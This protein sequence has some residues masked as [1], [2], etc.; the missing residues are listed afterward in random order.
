MSGLSILPILTA[1]LVAQPTAPVPQAAQSESLAV[2]AY[3]LEAAVAPSGLCARSKK[4]DPAFCQKLSEQ[5]L[6]KNPFYKGLPRH[7]QDFA[8]QA[9][10]T[11]LLRSFSSQN[12]ESLGDLIGQGD[13][14]LFFPRSWV[15]AS[16]CMSSSR[17]NPSDKY[18]IPL[19]AGSSV[20][21]IL[22][23]AS[24]Y[25]P[26]QVD[27]FA[28]FAPEGTFTLLLEDADVLKPN[29]LNFGFTSCPGRSFTVTDAKFIGTPETL[30]L[31]ISGTL[32]NPSDELP[33]ELSLTYFGSRIAS[34]LV[35]KARVEQAEVA[36]AR[37]PARAKEPKFSSIVPTA[38]QRDTANQSVSINGENIPAGT[39]VEADNGVTL[40]AVTVAKSGR[41]A[42]FKVSVGDIAEGTSIILTIK[43]PKG[44]VL[45][46]QSLRV[47]KKYVAPP[48]APAEP[49]LPPCSDFMAGL[50]PAMR[51]QG[52][53]K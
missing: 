7:Q 29:V 11:A 9:L 37:G 47:K 48:A 18:L 50:Q 2:M 41:V 42:S 52:R 6:S 25:I 38:V 46:T 10:S 22:A 40:S 31:Q 4:L 45:G 23:I 1:A 33:K 49:A 20:K 53:C 27:H 43:S 32:T 3:D 21:E 17:G 14:L 12:I 15:H 35:T 8:L 51:A 34:Y 16:A 13:S 19:P 24:K 5:L 30:K 26:T 28:E 44:E 36:S 39:T